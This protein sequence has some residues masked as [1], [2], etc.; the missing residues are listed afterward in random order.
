MCSFQ[1]GI[2]PRDGSPCLKVSFWLAAAAP[3]LKRPTSSVGHVAARKKM[4]RPLDI[5]LARGGHYPCFAQAARFEGMSR[6]D[7]R[8]D[9]AT[10]RV[11]GW[12]ASADTS[13][14]VFGG[15]SAA[16]I[17]DLW[18]STTWIG[19]S[20]HRAISIEPSPNSSLGTETDIKSRHSNNNA[21]HRKK[22]LPTAPLSAGVDDLNER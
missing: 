20:P 19:S 7:R 21:T 16:S 5:P 6:S 8:P 9:R 13:A 14:S 10:W 12:S 1:G 3:I 17:G 4:V 18:C 2:G 22:P 15:S 11:T